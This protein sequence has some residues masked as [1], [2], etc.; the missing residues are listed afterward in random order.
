MRNERQSY[1]ILYYK[2]FKTSDLIRFGFVVPYVTLNMIGW[3]LFLLYLS[4]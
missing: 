3:L 1:N 2:S 4:H